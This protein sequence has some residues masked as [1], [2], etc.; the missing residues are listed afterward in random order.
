M[1]ASP[2]IVY[3]VSTYPAAVR[4]AA[5][6]VPGGAGAPEPAAPSAVTDAVPVSSAAA[7]ATAAVPGPPKPD[8]ATAIVSM[9]HAVQRVRCCDIAGPPVER[10]ARAARGEF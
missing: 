10:L 8:S 1:V 6:R 4:S 7:W 9:T 3:S 5:R 2:V